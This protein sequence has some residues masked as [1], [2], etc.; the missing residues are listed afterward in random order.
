MLEWIVGY[1]VVG[2]VLASAGAY[3]GARNGGELDWLLTLVGVLIW[4][5]VTA[6]IIGEMVRDYNP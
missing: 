6:S 2:L 4:P 3:V 1:F 5:A